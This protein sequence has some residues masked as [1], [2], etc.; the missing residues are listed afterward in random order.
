MFIL[1]LPCNFLPGFTFQKLKLLRVTGVKKLERLSREGAPN[2]LSPISPII[3]KKSLLFKIPFGFKFRQFC[4]I[5]LKA[6][7]RETGTQIGRKY[8]FTL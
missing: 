1:P 3:K 6:S 4:G 2:L 5:S 8:I 7:Y